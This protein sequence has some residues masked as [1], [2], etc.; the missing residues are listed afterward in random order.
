MGSIRA[1]EL[2]PETSLP[3]ESITEKDEMPPRVILGRNWPGCE[4]I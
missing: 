3:A 2:E 4:L 1:G